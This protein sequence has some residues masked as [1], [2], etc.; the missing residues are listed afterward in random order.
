MCWLVTG[1]IMLVSFKVFVQEASV[2]YREPCFPERSWVMIGMA[3]VAAT[4]C[5]VAGYPEK[6]VS[7]CIVNI[8]AKGVFVGDIS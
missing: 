4:A 3:L 6:H 7:M 5:T 8:L 2:D 1:C